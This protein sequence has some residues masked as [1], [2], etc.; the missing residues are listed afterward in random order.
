M[1]QVTIYLDHE[2]EEK[3]MKIIKKSGVSKS[4]WIAGLIRDKTSETWP[5][6]ITRLAGK[7]KDLPSP[8]DLRKDSNADAPRE[9]I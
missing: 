2:T 7:W 9:S 3:M 4:K 6:S 8:E 5:E 1:G